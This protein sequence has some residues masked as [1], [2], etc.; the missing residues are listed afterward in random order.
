MQHLSREYTKA[1][2]FTSPHH[3]DNLEHF[4]NF[5]NLTDATSHWLGEYKAQAIHLPSYGAPPRPSAP[6]MGERLNLLPYVWRGRSDVSILSC[7]LVIMPRTFWNI[8]TSSN[9]NFH[10]WLDALYLLLTLSYNLQ[11]LEIIFEEFG[12]KSWN[13]CLIASNKT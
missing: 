13:G 3:F 4:D 11:L 5:E 8:L 9:T 12:V 2:P 7:H 10:G 1:H 6:P